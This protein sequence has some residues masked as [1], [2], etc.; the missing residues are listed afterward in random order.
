MWRKGEEVG[1]EKSV[2]KKEKS[3]K[4]SINNS[5]FAFWVSLYG[6][7]IEKQFIF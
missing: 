3:W 4:A 5:F 1:L 6:E 2:N 7:K